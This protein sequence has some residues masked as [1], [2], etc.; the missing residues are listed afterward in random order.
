MP[1]WSTPCLTWPKPEPLLPGLDFVAAEIFLGFR[2]NDVFAELRAVLLETQ[3]I[4]GIHGIF[5]RVI[6]TLAAL[7]AYHADNLAF[8]AFFSHKSLIAFIK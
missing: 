3:F 5:G 2:K 7:F 6:E 8:V 1:R 4:R